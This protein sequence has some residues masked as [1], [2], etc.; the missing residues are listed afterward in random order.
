MKVLT[1]IL[2]G[3]ADR[4]QRAL[5]EVTPLQAAELPNLD[6][7]ARV[8]ACGYL[9]PLGPGVCPSTDLAH[10]ELLGYGAFPYPGRAGFEA[11][12]LGVPMQPDEVIFRV[13]MAITMLD[14]NDRYVQVARAQLPEDDMAAVVESMSRYDS[15]HFPVRLHHLRGQSLAL[16]MGGGASPLVSDSDPVFYRTPVQKIVALDGAGEQASLT[17]LEL[18]RFSEWATESLGQHPVAERRIASGMNSPNS[19]LI[20]WPST[21]PEVP[22]FLEQWGFKGVVVADGMFH[23]G[24]AK[25]LGMELDIV[26]ASGASE[27]L[28][29]RLAA[30]LD[31][32]LSGFDFALVH[33]KAADEAAHTGKPAYKV[34]VLEELDKAFKPFAHSLTS[35]PEIATVITAD[36]TT[37]SG[38]SAEILHSGE[39]VPLVMVGSNTRV[40][41]V[42]S[43]D[44]VSCVSGSLG[45]LLGR[46]LMP[47]VL[48]L[49][50][51]ARFGSTRL[52][53]HDRPYD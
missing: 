27:E 17:A 24:L 43:F 48:N 28:G 40:D 2:D 5:G 16:V 6:A 1:V 25:A 39:S 49:T 36:H 50:D 30:A 44:E 46:D 51:R 11:L 20:K 32:L 41:S 15:E 47:L 26:T 42:L 14:G 29:L 7:L 13:N 35:D 52:G 23:C 9:Y 38:G 53:P 4:S 33:T 8:G 37:P 22:P 31:H 21:P 45:C 10:W 18:E 19:V 12:G 3:A 34:R